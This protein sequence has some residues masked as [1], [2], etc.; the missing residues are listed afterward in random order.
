M[1]RVGIVL[2]GFYLVIQGGNWLNG[3]LCLLGFI[4]AR[5]IVLRLTKAY[6]L[7]TGFV[8]TEVK[9]AVHES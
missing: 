5:V 2:A 3:L 4:A 6:E 1:L 8:N 7:K 9:E